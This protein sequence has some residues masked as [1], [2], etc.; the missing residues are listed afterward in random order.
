MR[1]R[2]ACVSDLSNYFKKKDLLG[3][4]TSIEQAQVRRNLGIIDYT[5]EGGQDTPI[6]LTY[7]QFWDKYN[8]S[9]L[10]TG[11]SYAITDFQTIYS[12]NVT[13]NAGQKITWG[14][15]INPSQIYKLYVRAL[16]KKE[17][18]T[19]VIIAGKN[20]E[21][22]YNP[23]R[24]TLPDGNM[25]KGKITFL[26]DDNGNMAFYDF[27][28]IKFNWSKEKL[29][30]A[31]IYTNTDLALYTFSN[32]EE[33]Q[34]QDSSEFAN[35][36]FNVLEKGCYNNVFIGD[37]YYN[38]LEPECQNNIFAKGMHDCLIKWNTV[39]NRFN[40]PVC[41]LT[42]SIYNKEIETGDTVLSTA[43]SKTIHKV[44]EATIISFLDP[45]TYAYQVVIL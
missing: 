45:I 17:I 27:K 4:L 11:A 5:G 23:K 36:K 32:I 6:E 12:S 14:K 30:E 41:Y 35:T 2:F 3:G 25:T 1:D 29:N 39:N 10:V 13:N 16:S 22:K 31:G 9:Q 26:V 24:E 34:V 8:S 43:I 21:V 37:T 38:I 15:D 33:G 19:R 20:W 7:A 44:N 18:D 40:E 42:G 28:N